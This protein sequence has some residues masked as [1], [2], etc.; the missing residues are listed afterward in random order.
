MDY[1]YIPFTSKLYY[2]TFRIK[3]NNLKYL[4]QKIIVKVK[5]FMSR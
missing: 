4:E 1:I 2:Y 3:C 5:A